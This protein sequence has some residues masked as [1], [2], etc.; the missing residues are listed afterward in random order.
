MN[1]INKQPQPTLGDIIG[2]CLLGF[3][4]SSTCYLAYLSS[5]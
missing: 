4:I 1:T 5:L 3:V 2:A